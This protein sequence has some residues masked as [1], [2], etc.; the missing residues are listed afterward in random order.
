MKIIN[1]SYKIGCLHCSF[2][3]QALNEYV[4][5]KKCHL[6]S[7][8]TNIPKKEGVSFVGLQDNGMWVL[9]QYVHLR[10]DG[11]QVPIEKSPYMWISHLFAA[12]N[13]ADPRDA[14]HITLPLSSSA[15][16]P[17][18]ELVK[19]MMKHNFFPCV[20]LMASAAMVVHYRSFISKFKFCP[21][22]IAFGEPGCGKTTALHIALA[23]LGIDLVRFISK[24][25]REKIVHMCCTSSLPLGVDDPHSKQDVCKT[26]IELFNGGKIATIGGGTKEPMATAIISANFTMIDDKK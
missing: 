8:Q 14:C 4:Q 5:Y 23:L 19:V 16:Q 15:L 9:N 17:T 10:C 20:L 25:S 22:P 1:S 21:I 3:D 11:S 26:A 2:S 24:A 18:L 13:I 12:P 6:S 7:Q